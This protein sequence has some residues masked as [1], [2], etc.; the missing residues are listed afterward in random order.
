[1]LFRGRIPAA[2]QPPAPGRGRRLRSAF[3]LLELLV[4]IGVI[5]IVAAMLLPV[6]ARAK[7]APQRVV[8]VNN[9]RQLLLG[10]MMYA[11]ENEDHLVAN[12]GG[13]RTRATP[14]TLGPSNWVDNVMTWELDPGNT[15]RSFVH[16][17]PLSPFISEEPSLYRCPADRALSDVQRQAGWRQRVRSYSMNGMVGDAGESMRSGHN[18]NNP[19]YVQFLTLGSIPQPEEIFVFIEEHPDSINDGYF[20]NRPDDHEWMDLPASTHEGAGVLSFADGHAEVHRWQ[21]GET[22]RPAEPDG[23]QL[24]FRVEAG[25]RQDYYWLAWRSSIQRY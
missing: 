5:G 14:L 17:S 13:D 23:A 4:V 24:P 7:R 6:I 12:G 16:R 9:T 22:L 2:S 1:M 11:G 21:N 18:V 20:L 8:C 25:R 10:W 19:E 15:N 3:T